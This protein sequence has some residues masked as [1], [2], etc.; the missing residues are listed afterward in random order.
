MYLEHRAT[1]RNQPRKFLSRLPGFGCAFRACNSHGMR[2]QSDFARY[3]PVPGVDKRRSGDLGRRHAYR[4]AAGRPRRSPPTRISPP[5]MAELKS[6]IDR[7]DGCETSKKSSGVASRPAGPDARGWSG[8]K[9]T[10]ITKKLL[11][12]IGCQSFLS[13]SPSRSPPVLAAVPPAPSLSP[14]PSLAALSSLSRR[15]R[16]SGDA[17]APYRE[18]ER[19]ARRAACIMERA[20]NDSAGKIADTRDERDLQPDHLLSTYPSTWSSVSQFV[21]WRLNSLEYVTELVILRRL[22][23]TTGIFFS[24]F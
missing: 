14:L 17:D 19:N 12:P 13:F 7:R 18:R 6:R 2:N 5:Q 21:I 3:M 4:I 11:A 24:H 16:T 8:S 10:I 23:G 15:M 20:S 9:I 1:A 22:Q